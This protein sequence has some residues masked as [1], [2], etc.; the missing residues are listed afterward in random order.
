MSTGLFAEILREKIEKSNKNTGPSSTQDAFCSINTVKKENLDLNHL[1][2]HLFAQSPNSYSISKAKMT[3]TPYRRFQN[4]KIY[5]TN[6]TMDWAKRTQ[7]KAKSTATTAKA[8]PRP[9]GIPHKLNE[10]QTLAMSFFINEAV[11]LLE[12]F[13]ADELKKAY[14]KLALIKHPDTASGS[15]P[16]FLELKQSYECLSSVFKK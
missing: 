8:P 15:A 14:R 1:H 2:Q 6:N 12:D 3:E 11:F 16:S 7:T 13:T 10:K 4:S 9:K 5:P